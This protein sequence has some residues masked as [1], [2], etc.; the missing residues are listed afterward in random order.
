MYVKSITLENLKGFA[1]LHFDFQRPDKS[2]A[3]WTVFV[4]GN[5][6]GK[7]TLLKSIA[8]ALIGPDAGYE[9]IGRVPAGWLARSEHRAKAMTQVDWDQ[10]HD[11]FKPSG[12]PPGG[13]FDAEVRWQLEKGE[14]IPIF[15]AAPLPKNKRTGSAQRGP[16]NPNAPG[17]FCAGYGPMRRLSG[18]STQAGMLTARGGVVSR[19]VTLFRE[20]A[21]LSESEAWLKTN[22]SRWLE[23]KS[24]ELKQL[25][26][27]VTALL[28]DDLLPH[29]MKISRTTVDHVFI[30]DK[31]GLELPMRDISDGCRSIYATVLDLV[32]GMFEVYG[33][34]GLFGSDSAGRPIVT[35]PGVVMID[36]I[37]AHLH[38]SWQR[39][40]P[41]WLKQHFPNVQF[42][43][44]THSPLVAQAADPNG[45]FVLPSQTDLNREPRPLDA[46]ELEKLRLGNAVK[47]LLGTAF[48]LNKTRSYWANQQIEQ[49][50]LLNAKAKSGAP[51]SKQETKKYEHLRE[52]MNLAFERDPETI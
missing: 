39:D 38:P 33:I 8:L 47:T 10:T 18:D 32:H 49:W 30:Q 43:V 36:E 44:T 24:P 2:Y 7:S 6:S 11:K 16:W 26:D 19:F 23:S 1:S 21:A 50:K 25:L 31:N 40:I 51:L 17:W 3:G 22:Y 52:Q 13:V 34:V 42:L 20:D 37:E 12:K 46:D 29:G 35:H 14:E 5:A 48:G 27:G 45:V 15:R 9:L 4:G 28:N 41:E